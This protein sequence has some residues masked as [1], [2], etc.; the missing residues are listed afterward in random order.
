MFVLSKLMSAMT[1]PLFWLAL[2]W[3]GALLMI[4]RWRRM[5]VGMLWLGLGVLGL[6]GFEAIPDA[7]LR[8][9]ETATRCRLRN[10]LTA[11]WA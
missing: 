8:P 9:L 6:L 2:W 11:M 3:G 10:C 5:A 7:L 4:S 1:Q